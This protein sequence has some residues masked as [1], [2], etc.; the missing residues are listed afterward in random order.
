MAQLV[1]C[2][3]P[4]LK[5]TDLI[6]SQGTHLSCRFH[7]RTRSVREATHQCF[8]LTWM[9]LP[10]SPSLPLSLKINKISKKKNPE[11]KKTPKEPTLDASPFVAA[12]KP[13]ILGAFPPHLNGQTLLESSLI[14][15][16]QAFRNMES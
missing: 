2:G 3:S 7:L 1:E 8:Y 10:L 12:P 14:V 9:L 11:N 6:P 15:A 16:T 13:I 4:K 5:V